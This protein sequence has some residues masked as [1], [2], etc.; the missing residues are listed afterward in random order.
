MNTSVLQGNIT[1]DI[2]LMKTAS[3]VSVCKFTIAVTRPYKKDETDFIRVTAWRKTAELISEYFRKGSKILIRGWIRTDSYDDKDG[4]KVYTTEVIAE[5]F[6]FIDK[7]GA[8]PSA[9]QGQGDFE[10]LDDEQM[11]F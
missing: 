4:K 3:G 11:P 2:E 9:E 5:E 7:K 1:K 8:T 6:D 10:P